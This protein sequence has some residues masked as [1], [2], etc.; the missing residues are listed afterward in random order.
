M[1]FA[2]VGLESYQFISRKLPMTDRQLD[3]FFS[4]FGVSLEEI[5]EEI[6][7]AAIDGREVVAIQVPMILLN[8]I[9]VYF[10]AM[11][12]IRISIWYKR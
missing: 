8:G 2:S 11:N 1:V 6:K 5:N 4:T 7:R 3:M 9:P 10:G 12:E